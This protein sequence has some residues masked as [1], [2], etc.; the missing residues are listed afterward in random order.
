MVTIPAR[1]GSSSSE[2]CSLA[3]A[4]TRC[5]VPVGGDRA[6]HALLAPVHRRAAGDLA[7]AR[8]LRDASVHGQPVKVQPDDPV[9]SGQTDP[10]Q[11]GP[12]PGV[13]P[14]GEATACGEQMIE[15]DPVGDAAAVTGPRG[16]W[17]RTR[18]VRGTRSGQPTRPTITGGSVPL[19]LTAI[20]PDGALDREERLPTHAAGSLVPSAPGDTTRGWRT[21]SQRSSVRGGLPRAVAAE[22]DDVIGC[23]IWAA[24]RSGLG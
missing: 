17:E 7:P 14:L 8:G 9:V 16:G 19:P 1:V 24:P 10:Q 15:H 21:A 4:A 11:R 3:R 22:G 23:M 2:S 5:A 13:D 6:L 12:V 18:G 20:L